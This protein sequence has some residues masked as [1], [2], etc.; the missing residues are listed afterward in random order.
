MTREVPCREEWWLRSR[1]ALLSCVP[2][3]DHASPSDAVYLDLSPRCETARLRRAVPAVIAV[4]G[5]AVYPLYLD[6]LGHPDRPCADGRVE[7]GHDEGRCRC[8]EE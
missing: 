7:P 6:L 3:G 2:T 4:F 5:P 1:L 8:R